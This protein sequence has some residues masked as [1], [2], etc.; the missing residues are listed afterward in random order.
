[1]P[2]IPSN[3]RDEISDT[4]FIPLYARYLEAHM[5][6][7]LLLDP[8]AVRLVE[9]LVH[10]YSV[11]KLKTHDQVTIIMRECEFDRLGRLFL[12][13]H[14]QAAVVHIGCG[15][16]TRFERV[17]NGSL[18]WYDLDLPEVIDLRR[19]LLPAHPRA[20][21]LAGS[22]F[23]PDWMSALA[24]FA[25]K[26]C[27]FLAEGVF[28]YFT[29]SQVKG[30]FIRLAQKFPGSQLV[31]DAMSPFMVASLNLELQ[32]AS[33]VAARLHWGLPSGKTPESWHPGIRLLGEWYYFD[34]PEPRL[35]S[36]RWMRWI[37]PVAHGIGV[38][39]YQLGG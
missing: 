17:D 38:Y 30:L 39:H 23:E 3:I 15:L 12:S 27:L 16:D 35:R 7:P 18:A 13:L 19:K 9:S 33:R 4:L 11:L 10:D 20:H 34:Q 31:C 21:L 25:G 36:M 37:R 14:P 1:M 2:A 26:D 29:E 28:P 32:V 6:A 8:T 22:V 5:P 24:G